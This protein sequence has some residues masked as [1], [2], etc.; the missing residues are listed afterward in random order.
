MVLDWTVDID[1]GVVSALFVASAV[2]PSSPPSNGIT[3]TLETMTATNTSARAWPLETGT[4]APIVAASS[5]S[6]R[7]S[8]HTAASNATTASVPTTNSEPI[9]SGSDTVFGDI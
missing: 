1:E 7:R 6:G 5:P 2:P 3:A 4:A 8:T 9:V